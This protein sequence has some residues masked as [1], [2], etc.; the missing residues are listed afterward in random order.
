[1]YVYVDQT[2]QVS[3]RDHD[4]F[5]ELKL[6]TDLAH[7]QLLVAFAKQSNKAFSGDLEHVWISQDWFLA[8]KPAKE[9]AWTQS[10]EKMM[11]YA[12]GKGWIRADI[13]AVR[14]HVERSL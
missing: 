1:M 3:L 5:T 12:F 2:G 9:E 13:A 11:A 10:S 6:V 7:D 8:Q 4:N 14:V